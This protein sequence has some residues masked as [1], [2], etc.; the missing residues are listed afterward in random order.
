[1]ARLLVLCLGRCLQRGVSGGLAGLTAPDRP[2]SRTCSSWANWFQNLPE[3]IPRPRRGSQVSLDYS[4]PAPKAAGPLGALCWHAAQLASSLKRWRK[5]I[6]YIF[7]KRRIFISIPHS[8]SRLR[9]SKS[10]L[11]RVV[12]TEFRRYTKPISSSENGRDNMCSW[13]C[14]ANEMR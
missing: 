3:R 12:A 6:Y 14:C 11:F 2:T 13:N 7:L 1:M 5:W 10:N 8:S 9:E 4:P